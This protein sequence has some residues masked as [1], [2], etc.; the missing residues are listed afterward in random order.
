MDRG[1]ALWLVAF[2]VAVAVTG[3]TGTLPA[4]LMALFYPSQ[5][6]PASGQAPANGPEPVPPTYQ[7]PGGPTNPQV[8]LGPGVL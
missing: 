7:G 1:L 8:P 5:L 4:V 6:V 2:G 3:L